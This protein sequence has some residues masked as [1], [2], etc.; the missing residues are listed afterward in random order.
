[1]TFINPWALWLM[2][3]VPAL[4][5][6]YVALQQKRKSYAVR[7]TN[8]EL[9]ETVAP[10]SPGWRRHVAPVLFLITL[11]LLI[12][13]LARPVATIRVPREQASIMLVMDVS[14]SMAA[15]DL[16]PNRIVAAKE[17]ANEFLEALPG[18]MRVGLVSFSDY[19]SL[20]TPLTTD[21]EVV[22]EALDGLRAQG[23]TAMGDGLSV[24]L[25]QI[26]TARAGGQQ[27]PA[28]ILVLSD[29]ETNR[30]VAPSD[31]A[32]R[33]RAASV[34][35]YSIG[36]GTEEGVIGRDGERLV[37]IQLNPAELE[38]VAGTTGGRFFRSTSSESLEE[39][40]RS[41]GSALGFRE[42]R[43][44][45]TPY[46]AGLAVFFLVATAA[47]SLLWFQRLP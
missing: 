36:I 8:L 9:L 24:A 47:L 21:K 7:F 33:A 26:E 16:E 37:R 20:V 42:E 18:P 1:M 2:V 39:I 35:V 11:V 17:A 34:P 41:V 3:L 38:A 43:Q 28:S 29:G 13:A 30:G 44:E 19:A 12:G 31:V 15:T 32:E 27:V 46:V 23:G 4:G 10:K 40:Y 14:G 5:A 25:D 6:L 22:G 45:L